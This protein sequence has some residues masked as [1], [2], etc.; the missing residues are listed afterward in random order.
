VAREDKI[1]I[2][3][4]EELKTEFQAM[5]ESMGMTMSGLGAYVIGNYMKEEKYK[6]EMQQKMLDQMMSPQ[7]LEGI[8]KFIDLGDPRIAKMISQAFSGI[9]AQNTLLKSAD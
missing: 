5:A 6:R 4:T 9:A 3:V 7:M 1:I 2:R 8:D